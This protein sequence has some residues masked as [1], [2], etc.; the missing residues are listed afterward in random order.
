MEG[1]ACFFSE[2]KGFEICIAWLRESR[3]DLYLFPGFGLVLGRDVYDG[4]AWSGSLFKKE[5]MRS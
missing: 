4:L 5:K 1:V 2:T 3:S